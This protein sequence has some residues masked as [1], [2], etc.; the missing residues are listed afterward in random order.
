M[1]KRPTRRV[2]DARQDDLFEARYPVRAPKRLAVAD[3]ETRLKRATSEALYEA[4]APR[5]KKRGQIAAEMGEI[6]GNPRFSE[7]M[8]NQYSAE[9]NETHH[10]SV[11]TFMALVEATE[12]DW[13]LDILADQRGCI[14]LAGDEAR[15]AERG[16]IR[17]QI[18]ALRKKE[19]A[20]AAQE[21]V[22]TPRGRS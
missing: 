19:R 18:D 2:L 4:R 16:H 15:D 3:F 21:P 13:L 6:L 7:F 11:K 22:R 14:V 9:S 5:S 12:C 17:R 10:M 1:A 20:L 8:L